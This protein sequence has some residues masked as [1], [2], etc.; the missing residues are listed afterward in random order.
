MIGGT[1]FRLEHDIANQSRL[2]AAVARGQSDIASKLRLQTASDDPAAAARIS[3]IARARVDAAAWTGVVA[4]GAALATRADAALASVQANFDR[5]R[6]LMTTAM[7][8]TASPSDRASVADELRGLAEDIDGL[9]G[10]TDAT[11][12]R[13]FPDGT[14]EALP[15]G[16]SERVTPTLSLADAFMSAGQTLGDILRGAAA[17]LVGTDPV[18]RDTA[19]SAI[20]AASDA[21]ATN[22]GLIGGR[23]ARLDA[24]AQRLTDRDATLQEELGALQ[25]TDIAATVAR[26]QADTLALDASR[27]LF[28]HVN[29]QT[30]FDLLG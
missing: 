12:Q 9:G 26:V 21:T 24:V 25:D 15:L 27:S 8:A 20:A 13:V 10:Q 30:L 29:R 19:L 3:Q 22:R 17:A 2:S 28:A 6:E 14:P 16:A 23:A 18:A 1:R 4:S 11:G 7:S 5:A